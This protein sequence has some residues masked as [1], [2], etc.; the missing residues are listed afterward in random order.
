MF[1]VFAGIFVATTVAG[2]ILWLNALA[3]EMFSLSQLGALVHGV[4]I[5]GAFI[6]LGFSLRM[7]TRG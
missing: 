6:L 1:K 7:I 5:S 3:N 4:G 2:F